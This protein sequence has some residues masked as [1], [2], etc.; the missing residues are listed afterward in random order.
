MDLYLNKLFPENFSGEFEKEYP[1]SWHEKEECPGYYTYKYIKAY[2]HFTTISSIINLLSPEKSNEWQV[3]KEKI[4]RREEN[5][6]SEENLSDWYIESDIIESII[7]FLKKYQDL[8]QRYTN[9]DDLFKLTAEQA[10]SFVK[11]GLAGLMDKWE[12]TEG[13]DT[14]TLFNRNEEAKSLIYFLELAQ[15]HECAVILI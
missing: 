9:K 7:E 4:V 8:L 10:Q 1:F 12:L 13:E 2:R 14:Y 5:V 11:Q 3:L 15:K 6:I